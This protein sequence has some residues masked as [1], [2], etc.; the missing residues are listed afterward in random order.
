MPLPPTH[1][2]THTTHTALRPQFKAKR[3]GTTTHTKG[4]HLPAH[5]L[6]EFATSQ[7][8]EVAR[9]AEAEALPAALPAAVDWR[10]KSPSVVTAP[11]NQ[12]GEKMTRE[13][14]R[15]VPPLPP[16]PL[17]GSVYMCM[18]I[19]ITCGESI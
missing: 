12:G 10:T 16:P 3:T 8:Q 14:T 18:C 9:S 5:I 1:T 2:H 17:W 15:G 13:Q 6:D 11:K 19:C 7:Q 4:R